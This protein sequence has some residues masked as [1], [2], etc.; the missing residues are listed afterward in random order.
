MAEQLRLFIV[1]DDDDFAYLM[2][3]SLERA[4]HQVTVCHTA[5]DALIVLSH[6]QFHLALLDQK[7]PDMPGLDLLQTLNRE[8]ITTPVLMVTAYGDE[9]LATQVLRAGALEYVVK[10]R[11]LTFLTDLAKRVQESVTRHRLQQTNRLL[12]EALESARD[13]V[14]ITDLQGVILHVNAALEQMFG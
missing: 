1:E 9:H 7:L 8:G 11:A 13:G 6:T 2:R 14:M 3:K 12:V 10:D 5:A 4:G